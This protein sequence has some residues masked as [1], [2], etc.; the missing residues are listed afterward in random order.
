MLQ[1]QMGPDKL[2]EVMTELE[3]KRY[4]FANRIRKTHHVNIPVDIIYMKLKGFIREIA[5]EIV[6]KE[7]APEQLEFDFGEEK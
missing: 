2:L 7:H 3:K 6:R 4:K 1:N 5:D